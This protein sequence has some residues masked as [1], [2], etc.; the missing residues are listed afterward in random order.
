MPQVNAHTKP[1]HIKVMLKADTWVTQVEDAAVHALLYTFKCHFNLLHHHCMSD[2]CDQMG[3]SAT[4][5]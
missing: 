1:E 3:G 4:T 5:K 2:R